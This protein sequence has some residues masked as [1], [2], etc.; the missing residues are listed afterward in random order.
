MALG[1]FPAA[2]TPVQCDWG[3]QPALA[4]QTCVP[5]CLLLLH[6]LLGRR[7]R[8]EVVLT[9]LAA[10]GAHGGGGRGSDLGQRNRASRR[11]DSHRP[12]RMGWWPLGCGVRVRCSTNSVASR[13]WVERRRHCQRRSW[14][15]ATRA[16]A[17]AALAWSCG[18]P[19]GRRMLRRS[20]PA[21]T[22]WAKRGRL[23]R[24][25][26]IQASCTHT[27]WASSVRLRRGKH[28][29]TS[30]IS[31]IWCRPDARRRKWLRSGTH[32]SAHGTR[33][34]E[35]APSGCQFPWTAVDSPWRKS[36]ATRNSCRD[37]AQG[38]HLDSGACRIGLKSP[39]P[40]PFL[41]LRDFCHRLLSPSKADPAASGRFTL[42]LC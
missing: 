32:A 39:R 30:W 28:D 38:H 10:G 5:D 40:Q 36:R 20:T 23:R 12:S 11:H 2:G 19:A 42:I 16:S 21:S 29:T 22:R 25:G 31:A 24:P 37:S 41:L 18:A 9:H 27:V 15:A 26:E 17:L 8:R 7:E 6:F 35:N 13:V 4:A 3:G 1:Q 14:K 33:G 34:A